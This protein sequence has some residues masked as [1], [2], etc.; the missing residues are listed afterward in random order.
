MLEKRKSKLDKRVG[1]WGN[2]KRENILDKRKNP[3]NGKNT[4]KERENILEK[5]DHVCQ[6]EKVC[7]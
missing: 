7:V 5:E 1:G 2:D 4:L 6:Q 3:F